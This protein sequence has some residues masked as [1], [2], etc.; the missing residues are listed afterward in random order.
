LEYSTG[1]IQG[2]DN[3]MHYFE[4]E[5]EELE[6]SYNEWKERERQSGKTEDEALAEELISEQLELGN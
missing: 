1:K 2:K 5:L 3:K 6:E 4:D